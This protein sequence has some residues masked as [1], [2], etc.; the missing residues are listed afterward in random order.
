MEQTLEQ[1]EIVDKKSV[2]LRLIGINPKFNEAPAYV[3]PG[4]DEIRGIFTVG[5]KEYKGKLISKEGEDPK[6][7]SA[8]NCPMP[9]MTNSES[10]RIAHLQAFD[11]N[12]PQ[13][14]FLL[15]MAL[16]S[17]FVAK[18]KAEVNPAQHRYYIENKETEAIEIVSKAQKIRKALSFIE[19]L[20]AEKLVDTAR[21]IGEY[22]MNMSTTQAQAALEKVAMDKPDR[23]LSVFG[24][25]DKDVK[26]FLNKLLNAGI[27]T[28]ENGQYHYNKQ[29]IGI[30]EAQTL[31]WLKDSNNKDVVQQMAK[32]IKSK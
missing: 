5:G 17:G 2:P 15:E 11:P 29:L 27:L 28:F 32:L 10:Y 22:V 19:T 1:T 13:Q 12:N 8:E 16:D 3:C 6:I 25:K 31:E 24:D 30:N 26:I 7:F 21:L 23:I 20:S 14:M 9:G 4:F 18:E